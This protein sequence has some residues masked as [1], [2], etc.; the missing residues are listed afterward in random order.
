MFFALNV[1]ILFCTIY[2]HSSI[3]KTCSVAAA[4]ALAKLDGAFPIP[5]VR[6]QI[7]KYPYHIKDLLRFQQD[8]T[9]PNN[10]KNILLRLSKSDP[11]TTE[12]TK[13]LVLLNDMLKS[14]QYDAQV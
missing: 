4:K 5:G 8:K 7:Y 10:V 3:D 1:S 2:W 12:A 9:H 14:F 13:C 6:T 11:L